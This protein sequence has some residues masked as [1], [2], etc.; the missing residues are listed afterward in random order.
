MVSE[1]LTAVFRMSLDA[2][3]FLEP[4]R[5]PNVVMLFKK[6][7]KTLSSNYRPVSLISVAR[8]LIIAKKI[9]KYLDKHKLISYSQ[10]GFTEGKSCL[11]NLFSF[12]M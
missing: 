12:Y 1:P 5:Q 3:E 8:K 2:D 6:G 10:Y 4:W 7:D 11:T 9:R